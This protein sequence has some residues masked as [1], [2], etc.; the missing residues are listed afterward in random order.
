VDVTAWRVT[1]QSLIERHPMLRSTFPQYEDRPIQKVHQYQELDWQEI[2]ASPWS[3]EELEER[4]AQVHQ[5]PFNLETDPTLGV[6]WFTSSEQK[7]T[8]ILTI[9]HIAFDGWSLDLVLEELLT[10]YQ[11]QQTG[12]LPYL[13]PLTSSYNDYV[14]WQQHLLSNAQGEKLWQYWQQQLAGELPLLNLPTARPRPTIQG[15]RGS[16]YNFTLTGELGRQLKE[17]A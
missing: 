10:L 9:H 6:R 11:S 15:D 17:L 4:L 16:T 12:E 3:E 8:F 13:T 1:F 14:N 2:D 5:Q 7:H